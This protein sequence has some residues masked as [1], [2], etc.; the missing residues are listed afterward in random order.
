MDLV[1]IVFPKINVEPN[2]QNTAS[3][4]KRQR[5]KPKEKKASNS[6]DG[7]EGET[8]NASGTKKSK[9]K[10]KPENNKPS[11][12]SQPVNQGCATSVSAIKLNK[13]NKTVT[14]ETFRAA[15]LPPLMS[16]SIDNTVRMDISNNTNKKASK[17][18]HS[19]Y[20][21]SY[22]GLSVFKNLKKQG[23]NIWSPPKI[24]TEK[25][26][27]SNNEVISTNNFT[28]DIERI[29]KP[30]TGH[31][32]RKR[33]SNKHVKLHTFGPKFPVVFHSHC[34]EQDPEITMDRL[35]EKFDNIG[36]NSS[37]IS[38]DLDTS[39]QHENHSF[40]IDA[41]VNTT[42]DFNTTNSDSLNESSKSQKKPKKTKR[43]QIKLKKKN[44]KREL[45]YPEFMQ[46]EEVNE[47]LK[48]GSLV[49]GMIRINPRNYREAYV[50][51]I[52][53]GDTDY[54]I[55]SVL[56]Q[57]RALEG[58]E[59]VLRIKP[60]TEWDGGRKTASVVYI[61][62][63][64][65]PRTTVGK[66]SPLPNNENFA[67]FLPRDKR[68]PYVYIPT[69]S[70]PQ[71]FKTNPRNFDKNLFLAKITEWTNLEY[72]RGLIIENIGVSGDLKIENLAI[73]KYCGLD[74]EP[75]GNDVLKYL[76][77]TADLQDD[78]LVGREDLRKDCIFTID[79][80]TARDLDDAVSCKTLPD[81]NFEIG[82]HIADVTFFLKEGTDLD[83]QVAWKATT[84]YMVN[85]VYHML[86]VELCMNC[87]LLPGKDRLSFSVFWI[88]TPEGEVLS[89]RFAR[90][91]MNSCVQLAYEHAQAII[92]D[93]DNFDR[94]SLP[95][96]T[97]GYNV[98]DAKDVVLKLYQISKILRRKRFENG[99]L[100][101]DQVKL[102][103]ELDPKTGY[104]V[105]YFVQ[106][107]KESNRL[108]EEFMLL[109]NISVAE[110]ILDRFPDVAFLRLHEPP[111]LNMLVELKRALES[112]GIHVDITSAKSIQSSLLRY[113]SDD[114]AG[115]IRS[116]VLNHLFAKPM[117]RARYFCP[118]VEVAAESFTHYALNVP[119]YT[120]FTSPIRR[121]ADVMVH[122]LL[123]ASLG[124]AEKPKLS[125][126]EVAEVAARCNLIKYN[127]KKAQ[128][129]SSH[130]YLCHY[131]VKNQPFIREAA[132][133]EV[134]ERS[135]D[136]IVMECGE[137]VRVHLHEVEGASYEV[138]DITNIDLDSDERE[139]EIQKKY[140]R[141]TLSYP[142]TKQ[143]PAVMTVIEMF[144]LVRVLLKKCQK[145]Q[146][147]VARLVRP[148]S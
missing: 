67:A 5:K 30:S 1:P 61:S 21:H 105:R 146:K 113:A 94:S 97:N 71:G 37:I 8:S 44:V 133:V 26:S 62:N 40:M 72:A 41:T 88:M 73:M 124:L 109:A 135:F 51:S 141:I 117:T 70:W 7:A 116:V 145:T 27:D 38:N 86:P 95:K 134:R 31:F 63:M 66:L 78:W 34:T 42:N 50:S 74:Y 47:G 93:P 111:K 85:N 35:R 29:H 23:S 55:K 19:Y 137:V 130:L 144:T 112:V 80:L 22:G 48:N 125:S 84:I 129:E 49:K 136:V 142:P 45:C 139:Q 64:V 147:L 79:P 101:I 43:A 132:V 11:T 107:L 92:E 18:T 106:E 114:E 52:T 12:S 118:A 15:V 120:H 3:K 25:N 39:F 28:F 59:V 54:F 69:I 143:Y 33:S 108:I 13:K 96:I 14:E 126:E 57:N 9:Q 77:K 82:V 20:G 81:G 103:F 128:E 123:A 76:P 58:D 138:E 83:K 68:F 119:L 100:R 60:E 91:V 115:K 99:A 53:R 24:A 104:P 16:I 90:T 121:Y 6:Q 65:H 148:N 75:F 17:K 4:K 32:I 2:A 127:A 140:W 102:S 87:S 89:T 110:K 56:D 10:I 131:I 36:L 46:L 122:R 98:D